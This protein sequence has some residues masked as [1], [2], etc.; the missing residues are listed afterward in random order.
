MPKW[1]SAFLKFLFKM[2]FNILLIKDPI[3]RSPKGSDRY[4]L[5]P[6]AKINGAHKGFGKVM[7]T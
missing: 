5:H 1:A 2:G 4:M 3:H 7:P 6:I